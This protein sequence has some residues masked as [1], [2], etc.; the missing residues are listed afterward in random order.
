[1]TGEPYTDPDVNSSSTVDPVIPT[2]ASGE[3]PRTL[4]RGRRRWR[5][6]SGRRAE[7][8][9]EPVKLLGDSSVQSS[10]RLYGSGRFGDGSRTENSW[11]V[12][13]TND[14][15]ETRLGGLRGLS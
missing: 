8:R 11:G 2:A 12:R 3:C 6:K 15:V 10:T 5:A 4:S 13:N 1:M 9:V 7:R 14:G